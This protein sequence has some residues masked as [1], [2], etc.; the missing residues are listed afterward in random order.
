MLT[1][2]ECQKIINTRLIELKFGS[3]PKEM[4][5]PIYYILS[6]GGKRIR[7]V[8]LLLSCN[9]FS[10]SVE[11]AIKPA[12][13]IELFHNFTLMHDD[14]MDQS[15]LRRGKPAI[16][17]KWNM[18]TAVLSGD[19]MMIKAYDHIL[20]IDPKYVK[21]IF[22]VFNKTA[23]EVCEGQQY[24]ILFENSDEVSIN[25]YLK[26]I[27]L[28][29]AVLIACS[30]Q[31]G[32]II[33][34]ANKTDCKLLYEFGE[35]LGIAFQ[36][37]DDLLDV[38]GDPKKFGKKIG[39][40]ILLNKKTFLLINALNNASNT[41]KKELLT[42]LNKEHFIKEE[43]ISAITEIYNSLN[44]SRLTREKISEF[45]DKAY[46]CLQKLSLKKERISIIKELIINIKNRT[47]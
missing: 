8:L 27:R 1:F 28:K 40:D 23:L 36:L 29:T 9:I 4:Y 31:I 45:F 24:D 32:G 20:D 16:H 26:M 30:A 47:S 18:N 10:D 21:K 43:K 22:R 7:P 35:N 13:G 25:E 14:L 39:G 15:D 34:N 3:G 46:E 44:I 2:E 17:K 19:A 41:T 42:W 33:G 38:Y 37:Q 5:D 12:I 11:T 6:L